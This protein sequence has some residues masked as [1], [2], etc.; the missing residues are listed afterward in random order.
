MSHFHAIDDYYVLGSH[1]KYL[2]SFIHDQVL[3]V[4]YR[5]CDE[6]RLSLDY[7]NTMWERFDCGIN[8]AV[9]GS[10]CKAGTWCEA[11][12]L[13]GRSCGCN[14]DSGCLHCNV[15][16]DS[17]VVRVT[18]IILETNPRRI[19]SRENTIYNW[20][21]F[22]ICSICREC[23]CYVYHGRWPNIIDT[24]YLIESSLPRLHE[25]VQ[26]LHL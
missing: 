1:P 11:H 9:I 5:K 19:V 20:T 2:K 13:T 12:P 6:C 4:N 8:G 10:I 22:D 15:C 7:F 16:N 26:L 24:A 18:D 14:V 3:L 17:E 23:V 21:D 25:R